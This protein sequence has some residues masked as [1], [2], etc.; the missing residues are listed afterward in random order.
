[1]PEV[2]IHDQVYLVGKMNARKQFHVVRR[3]TP[4]I[5]HLTPLFSRANQTLIENEDGTMVPVV[6]GI[7]IFEGLSAVSDTIAEISDSDADYVIDTCLDS[8]KFRSN[9][10]WAPL[11]APGSPSGAGIM[12]PAADDLST[13]LRLVWEVLVYNLGNFSLETLLPSQTVNPN[14]LMA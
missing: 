9:G 14:G 3:L 8:V 2:A 1:M 10:G 12:L 7:S 4:M 13:Q 6:G 11:K 5:K